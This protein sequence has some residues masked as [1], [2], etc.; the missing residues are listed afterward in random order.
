VVKLEMNKLFTHG[1]FIGF[2]K[3]KNYI[4]IAHQILD[5]IRND[6]IKKG[7]EVDK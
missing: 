6:Y 4:Y 1:V 3:L 5:V 7:V 2:T